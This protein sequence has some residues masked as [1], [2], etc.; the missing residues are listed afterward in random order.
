MEQTS[1]M[2]DILNAVTYPMTATNI[3][4]SIGKSKGCQIMDE[5]DALVA[6]G[7]LEK[8]TSGRNVMYK[9]VERA[10]NAVTVKNT[11]KSVVSDA[12]A[13]EKASSS[14]KLPEG[15]KAG[16]LRTDADGNVYR[17][18]LMPNGSKVKLNKGYTLLNINN[19]DK[20]IQVKNASVDGWVAITKYVEDH[21]I[22]NYK[23]EVAGVGQIGK[24]EDL[25][26]SNGILD[27]KITRHNKA[28]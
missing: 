5:L 7:R 24:I 17:N 14:H 15:Y 2:K 19:G 28:A 13:A 8:D 21:N 22:S 12:P 1:V 9:K 3:A 11:T 26:G 6:D 10:R 25:S 23:V 20:V 16:K 18:I 27:V 4:H